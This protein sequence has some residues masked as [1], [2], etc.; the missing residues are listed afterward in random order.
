M[1][2]EDGATARLRAGGTK[3]NRQDGMR[4]MAWEK[5]AKEE[6]QDDLEATVSF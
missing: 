4:S 5:V 6:E 3:G 2:K 1:K